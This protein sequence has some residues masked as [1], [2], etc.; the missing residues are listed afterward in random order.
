[1]NG[2]AKAIDVADRRFLGAD[3]PQTNSIGVVY[4]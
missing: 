1:M 4:G 2:A 3:M